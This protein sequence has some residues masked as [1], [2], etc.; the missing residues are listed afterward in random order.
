MKPPRKKKSKRMEQPLTLLPTLK[1]KLIT[2]KDFGEV[3][4]FFFD[5]FGENEHFMKLGHAG[6]HELLEQ[7]LVHSAK[8]VLRSNVIVMKNAFVILLPEQQF[9]HG[10]G[11]FNDYL[12]NF[13]YF[14]DIDA[15]MLALAHM[16]FT[17]E[18][19]LIRF[20]CQ[21]LGQTPPRPN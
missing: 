19:Q 18:T 17:D 4:D 9:V 6:R 11:Q 10:A 20:S 14:E 7:V 3:F 2:A 1:M 8:Q 16:P 5:Y 21:Q 13:F 15:G 12:A